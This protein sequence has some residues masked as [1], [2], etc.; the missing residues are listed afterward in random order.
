MAYV[1]SAS[2]LA[3]VRAAYEDSASYDVAGD[4]TKCREF[5]VAC[6]VLKE[7]IAASQRKGEASMDEDYQKYEGA[8]ARAIAWLKQNDATVTAGGARG[9]VRHMSFE[10]FRE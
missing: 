7:R 6:R 9:L 4:A 3:A 2:T 10:R 5:I 1:S 8:E